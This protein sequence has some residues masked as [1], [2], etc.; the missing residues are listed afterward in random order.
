M[1]Q[2]SKDKKCYTCLGCTRLEIAE[3]EGV[4]R[5]QNYVEG[6]KDGY[7]KDNNKNANVNLC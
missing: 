5:C 1:K 4:Y 6:A 2:I 3:F 7:C